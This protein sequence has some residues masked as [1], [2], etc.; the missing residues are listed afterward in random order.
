MTFVFIMSACGCFALTIVKGASTCNRISSDISDCTNKANLDKSIFGCTE[1]VKTGVFNSFQ[2][3]VG[4][5][6]YSIGLSS[7]YT[8]FINETD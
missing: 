8:R 4:N 2:V 7:R 1:S 3:S 5:N 6:F